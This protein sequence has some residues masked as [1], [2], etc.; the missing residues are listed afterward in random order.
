MA[1][2]RLCEALLGGT[3]FPLYGDGSQSRDF[4]HVSDAVDATLRA[5]LGRRPGAVYN[6]GGGHEAT[7]AEVITCSR[8]WPVAPPCST[9]ARPARRRA[10]HGADTARARADLGWMPRVGLREGLRSPLE[11][12][13][14][15][16]RRPRSGRPWSRRMT[17]AARLREAA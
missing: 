17:R 3:P 11:W 8:T 12:V 4:T 9:A 6:V 14:A 13:A 7:L 5:A 16:A 10:A 15:R 2:R 1:M